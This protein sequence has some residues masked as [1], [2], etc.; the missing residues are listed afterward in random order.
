[1]ISQQSPFKFLAPFDLNDRGVYF[2]RTKEIEAIYELMFQTP[3]ALIFGLSGTGKTS[4]I[5]CGL[6]SRFNGPDWYPIFIRRDDDINLSIKKNLLEKMDIDHP[7]NGI[8]DAVKT[9]FEDWWRPVY[10][11]FDQFE[12]VFTLGSKEERNDF[13]L[14]LRILLDSNLKCKILLVM[15]E[16]YIGRLKDLEYGIP[17]IFD[18][19]YRVDQ[20]DDEHVEEVILSSCEAFNISLEPIPKQRCAEIIANLKGDKNDPV[21]LPYLQIY[22]DL[23]YVDDFKR[24][25]PNGAENDPAIPLMLGK[26]LPLEFKSDEIALLGNIDVVLARFLEQQSA[27]TIKTLRATH[28]SVPDDFVSI[29][30]DLL[31]T[32][33]GTRK[34]L[35]RLQDG[36]KYI[37]LKEVDSSLLFYSDSLISDTFNL[38]YDKRLL[39]ITESKIELSHE[40]LA[41]PIDLRRSGIKEIKTRIESVYLEWKKTAK[42]VYLNNSQLYEMKSTLPRVM[43]LLSPE[44]NKFVKKSILRN[45]AKWITGVALVLA[46]CASLLY[47]INYQKETKSTIQKLALQNQRFVQA[48]LW[49]YV[50][51]MKFLDVKSILDSTQTH[52][53]NGSSV[54]SLYFEL[55]YFFNECGHIDLAKNCAETMINLDQVMGKIAK[56]QK[57]ALDNH[58]TTK[59][60]R[61]FLYGLDPA[62]FDS[63]ETKYIPK[64]IPIKGGDFTFGCVGNM[65]NC[66]PSPIRHKASV[67]DFQIAKTETTMHQYALYAAKLNLQLDTLLDNWRMI[68]DN[69]IAGVTWFDAARY[70]NWMSNRFE[71]DTAYQFVRKT[72]SD[73]WL[74]VKNPKARESFRLPTEVEWEYAAKGGEYQ[75]SYKYAGSDAVR[76]VAWYRDNSKINNIPRPH[77]VASLAPNTCGLYD[78]S[79]NVWEWC[80]EWY[81]KNEKI[82]FNNDNKI[83][84]SKDQSKSKKVLRGGSYGYDVTSSWVF[85]RGLG[86]AD[87]KSPNF[88]F[89]LVRLKTNN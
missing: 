16:E 6:A 36:G 14:N 43:P 46:S 33:E 79:G 8:N 2:G 37:Q 15:R 81:V 74:V 19:T 44:V 54:T 29:I 65:D 20:M 18:F 39:D 70:A 55:S 40:T 78:M 47:I 57:L 10:L 58:T 48:A 3:L 41:K 52:E 85:A 80:D 9:I 34:P 35:F 38:L 42:K 32:P 5:R 77:K 75:S 87:K 45:Q 53:N 83:A 12:E 89:R 71:L 68:G 86:Y 88:G 61:S 24:T 60:F 56:E 72:G 62:R 11:I 84:L 17:E 27:D 30:L 1:M 28:P 26:H 4:L 51:E 22:L 13:A 31:L 66:G 63:A 82:H 69:P 23:L 67:G 49:N 64:M 21:H 76:S 50:Y 59:S 73:L 25:Y 7:W